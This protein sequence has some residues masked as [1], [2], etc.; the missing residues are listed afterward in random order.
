[1]CKKVACW[2]E[3][4]SLL[5]DQAEAFSLQL[6]H[7]CK[8]KAHKRRT[9]ATS[10]MKPM[11]VV[12]NNKNN[13]PCLLKENKLIWKKFEKSD[14]RRAVGQAIFLVVFHDH[15]MSHFDATHWMTP[16][17]WTRRSTR[18]TTICKI[19]HGDGD[20]KRTSYSK[21]QPISLGLQWENAFV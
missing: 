16:N 1:M 17:P 4:D 7:S 21:N 9:L 11:K 19:W 14:L 3:T 12:N 6:T 13:T 15:N 8:A 20:I 2:Y 18:E 5:M 10:T